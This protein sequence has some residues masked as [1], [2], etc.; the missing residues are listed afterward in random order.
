MYLL[1]R[2]ATLRGLDSQKWA[3]DTGTAAAEGLGTAVGVWA[4]VLS[5]GFG[6]VTWTSRWSDLSSLEKGFM[7]LMGSAKYIESITEGA[8]FVNGPINDTLYEI[9]Y[10]GSSVN[11]DARYVGTVSAVC[12][13][14]N[15]ARGMMN[16]IEIAQRVEKATGVSTGFAAG[17]TG[18]YGSVLWIAGYK[19]IEEF[20]SGQ[21]ALAADTSFVEF[22]DSTTGAYIADP[23]VTQSTLHMRL[24]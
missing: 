6:T 13:P 1:A 12:A 2:Q 23:M 17:Q 20:E 14:G 19:N 24:N 22:I 8:Q 21:H 11:D 16:G 9:V 4:T 15:F 5:P 18:A 10:E 3:V 7:Q